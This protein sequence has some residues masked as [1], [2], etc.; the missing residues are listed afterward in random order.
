[1]KAI[2]ISSS[3]VF[4]I[5]LSLLSL[6]AFAL[7]YFPTENA[8]IGVSPDT[9]NYIGTAR[10]LIAGNGFLAYNNS[11]LLLF[12][13]LYPLVL[14]GLGFIFKKDPLILANIVNSILFGLIVF[15]AGKFAFKLTNRSVIF[16]LLA[17]LSIIFSIPLYGVTTMAWSETLFIFLTVLF[18]MQ[19]NS[20]TTDRRTLKLVSLA[21]LAA[22]AALTRYVGVVLIPVGFA[23]IIFSSNNKFKTKV[24]QAAYY[25]ILSSLPVG[26]WLLRNRIIS[27]TFTGARQLSGYSFL[28][29]F[30]SMVIGFFSWYFKPQLLNSQMFIGVIFLL[31]GL[32]IGYFFREY[33]QQKGKI[34]QS[35]LLLFTYI[36]LYII[37]LFISSRRGF[38]GLIDI[39]YLTPLFIPIT[40]LIVTLAQQGV[41]F[42]QNRLHITL[43]FTIGVIFLFVFIISPFL[44]TAKNSRNLVYFRLGYTTKEVS[45]SDTLKFLKNNPDS[46]KGCRIYTNN[47]I[48]VDLIAH[49][50]AQTS[51]GMRMNDLTSV[52]ADDINS[53]SEV[54]PTEQSC[55]IWFEDEQD[56]DL[57]SLSDLQKIV[58]LEVLNS[59]DDGV[60][61]QI[62]KK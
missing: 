51:P 49:F 52:V 9:V 18:L 47:P 21:I 25:L 50:P 5:L 13:P 24:S 20:Y 60:I 44:T 37:F 43:K 31:T 30:S 29:N 7:V 54:W 11:P 61:Y 32:L 1:M 2:K 12:P 39:R 53:L 46:I 62:V 17:V 15:V 36:S 35:Q 57:Y 58:D 19:L 23:R 27:G 22:L 3:T 16:S 42:L 55:L 8:R 4:L 34:G 48:G 45:S 56:A 41:A 59:F 14:A 40:L 6:L 38:W 33:S 10:N 28:D 26:A